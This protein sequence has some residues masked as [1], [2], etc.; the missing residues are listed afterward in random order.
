M[1][2]GKYISLFRSTHLY[3]SS[4]QET[5]R[6]EVGGEK[7]KEKILE[8]IRYHLSAMRWVT[9]SCISLL[10]RSLRLLS[11][12]RGKIHRE[13]HTCLLGCLWVDLNNCM[14]SRTIAIRYEDIFGILKWWL[15]GVVVWLSP[16]VQKTWVM[17]E[18]AYRYPTMRD[19]KE[20]CSFRILLSLSYIYC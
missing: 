10:Q 7:T 18:S 12:G 6:R 2:V 17:F 5:K 14:I 1:L 3:P 8:L 16:L 13:W 20:C 4:T 19:D 15:N 11:L 9:V